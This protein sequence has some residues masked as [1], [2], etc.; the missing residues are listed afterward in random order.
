MEWV[1]FCPGVGAAGGGVR[2]RALVKQ[3]RSGGAWC[4][5]PENGSVRIAEGSESLVVVRAVGREAIIVEEAPSSDVVQ[6]AKNLIVFFLYLLAAFLL[7]RRLIYIEPMAQ[8]SIIAI[9]LAMILPDLARFS[10]VMVGKPQ[11]AQRIAS[12]ESG[13]L[14]RES[15]LAE[16]ILLFLTNAVKLAG[17][18]VASKLM[19]SQGALLVMG[20]EVV[21][22]IFVHLGVISAAPYQFRST[23]RI[24]IILMDITGFVLLSCCRRGIAPLATATVFFSMVVAYWLSKYDID[25]LPPMRE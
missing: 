16:R 12:G 9:A 11:G 17:F 4:G 13:A 5:R 7:A 15:D 3:R 1:C 6:T 14:A 10:F 19:P 20:S 18:F 24:S 25:L 21:F 22:N 23:N 2:S 8:E